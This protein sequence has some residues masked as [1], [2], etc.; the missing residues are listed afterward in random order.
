[1]S[2]VGCIIAT[3]ATNLIMGKRT[4]GHFLQQETFVVRRCKMVNLETLSV[5]TKSKLV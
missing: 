2:L 1:M 4:G 3:N 5:S